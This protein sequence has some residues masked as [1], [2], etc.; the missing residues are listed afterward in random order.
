MA[1]TKDTG[2]TVTIEGT[3]E[4]AKAG[5]IVHTPGSEPVY[6]D[7]LENGWPKEIH[8]KRVRVTGVR[9]VE[10]RIPDPQ[11]DPISAGA[12][13]DQSILYDAKWTVLP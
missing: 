1:S 8:R 10:K 2:T 9:R 7:G 4:D 5:A 12:F 13:G 6:I 3:A 11:T